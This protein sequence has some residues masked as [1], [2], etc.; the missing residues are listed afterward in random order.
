MFPSTQTALPVKITTPLADDVLLVHSVEGEESISHLFSYR[1]A[2]YSTNAAVDFTLIVGKTVTVSIAL[3]SGGARYINGVVGRFSQAGSDARYVSYI[4][5]VRPSLWLLTMSADCRIFQNM[6]VPDIIRQVFSGLGFSA[7]KDSLT[8]TYTARNYCVQ[9]RETAFAFVSRLME[10]EGIFYFFTHD[11]SSHTMVLADDTSSWG[12]CTGLS[13]ARYGGRQGDLD[14]DDVI[15]NCSVEQAVTTGQYQ[16]D[17]YNFLTP[18]TDLLATASGSDTSRSVYDYPGLYTAQG[19]GETITSKRLASFEI[20]GSRIVGA[21][22]CRSFVAGAKFTLAGHYRADAN[23]DYVIRGLSLRAN[24]ESYSNTFEGF[25]ATTTFR[26]PL[27][28]PRPFIAGTQ[29]AVV[30]GK[31]G[32]EIW[33]DQYGRIA[34]QF[35]WDRVGQNN[36]KSSCWIRVSQGW[37]GKS[38]G[39]IFLPRVGQEV[40]EI[41]RASCRERVSSPV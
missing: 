13:A 36:E 5:D 2:L 27:A 15:T 29:T 25:I 40:V 7:F 11:S 3:S 10:E 33:T 17:D 28:T 39:T 24:Q 16:T 34:V 12:T 9:Y 18:A 14:A 19:D 22:L 32:E 31:S 41:G 8:A 26:P 20:D 23:T 21:G 1:V 37:A 6:T 38:W 35:H 30:V 4:A